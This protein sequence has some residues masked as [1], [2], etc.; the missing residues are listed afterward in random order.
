MDQVSDEARSCETALF[1]SIQ[2]IGRGGAIDS[3][4]R[5]QGQ[6]Y[7]FHKLCRTGVKS[8]LESYSGL[9]SVSLPIAANA[10]PVKEKTTGSGLHISQTV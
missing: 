3:S 6:G 8:A 1:Y 4:G 7:T 9:G 2:R 5:Q 10:R